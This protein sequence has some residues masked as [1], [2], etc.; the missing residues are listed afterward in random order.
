MKTVKIWE[1]K[2]VVLSPQVVRNVRTRPWTWAFWPKIF[3]P[4]PLSVMLPQVLGVCFCPSRLYL[5]RILV[6]SPLTGKC[7]STEKVVASTLPN[8][9]PAQAHVLEALCEEGIKSKILR[10][11]GKLWAKLFPLSSTLHFSHPDSSWQPWPCLLDFVLQ[12]NAD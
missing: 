11:Q 6:G 12:A 10:L 1:I 2:G 5:L 4:S 3:G 8:N 9:A 7:L